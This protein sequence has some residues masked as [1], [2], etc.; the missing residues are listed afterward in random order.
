MIKSDYVVNGVYPLLG[1]AQH[2]ID[3]YSMVLVKKGIWVKN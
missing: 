3:R 2:R 1:W